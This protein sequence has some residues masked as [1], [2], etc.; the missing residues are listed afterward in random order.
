MKSTY[1]EHWREKRG[2]PVSL[3]YIDVQYILLG[4][5]WGKIIHQMDE[6]LRETKEGREARGDVQVQRGYCRANYDC[7][8]LSLPLLTLD[9]PLAHSS[10]PVCRAC[11]CAVRPRLFLGISRGRGMKMHQCHELLALHNA[12]RITLCEIYSSC[13]DGLRSMCAELELHADPLG[14]VL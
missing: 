12:T 1:F 8:Q 6:I 10:C 9:N 5:F 7:H 3:S 2:L 13:R 4:H 11:F 14:H